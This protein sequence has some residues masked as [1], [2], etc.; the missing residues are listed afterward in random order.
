MKERKKK[1]LVFIF[2]LI[3]T[4][5]LF[6]LTYQSSQRKALKQLTE[7]HRIW[8]ERDV[9]YIITPNEKSVFLQLTSERE[10]D[11]FIEAFW[12]HR[13]PEPTT[14]ENEFKEEHYKRLEHANSY[15]GKESPGPGW[16]SDMGKIYII[17]GEP[18][19]IE[20]YES[21]A[22]MYP[23]H[24]WYYQGMSRFGLP[25]TFNIVYFKDKGIGE[26]RLYSPIR[27][28]PQELL[29]H[30]MGNR[31]DYVSAFREL[32]KVEPAVAEIS[33]TLIPGEN[34]YGA[35]RP[36]IASD[37]LI[38]EQIPSMP[39]RAVEDAYAEK[40]LKY[41]DIIEVD[42][43][44]N[45]IGNEASLFISRDETGISYVHYAIEPR[46]LSFELYQNSYHT[47]LDANVI[48]TDP[49]GKMVFQYERRIP[50]RLDRDEFENI[51]QK[52]FSFQDVFPL[53]EG[54]FKL[55]VLLKN[56]VTKEFTSIEAD[57][58]IPSAEA[59]VMTPPILANRMDSDS[60]Y[61]EKN[62][63]FLFGNRQLV[64]SPRN[65]FGRNDNLYVFFQVH[66]MQNEMKESGKIAYALL[67][68]DELVISRERSIA[69]YPDAQNFLEK[70]PLADFPP[71]HYKL[72]VSLLDASD[73][74]LL[75]ESEMFYV[76]YSPEL[77]RPWLLSVPLPPSSDP[78]Y[79]NI[80]GN[81]WLKTGNAQKAYQLLEEAYRR[82]PQ[83]AVFAMDY[84]RILFSRKKYSEV[85]QIAASFAD[86]SENAGFLG[87]MGDSSQALGE[88]AQA[89][90]YYKNHLERFG[91]NL[92]ILNSIGLCYL[93][94][95]NV[96]E[97]LVAWEKSL[98]I[99]PDQEALEKQVIKLRDQQIEND[100]ETA[101]VASG[102]CDLQ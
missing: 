72:Q 36:S 17:L 58:T 74:T 78:S 55:S 34:S 43:T 83:S 32:L 89:V 92:R 39:H 87:L 93:K 68:D 49:A 25:D 94:L 6:G 97:A 69:D 40:L 41:K 59:L 37:I 102:F 22:E 73:K 66:G 65:D 45:Y 62:K 38:E 91:T 52:L 60:Q 23:L 54:N 82:D 19:T 76:S 4:L 46:R 67:K 64:L 86:D 15:F 44:A 18:K 31:D 81:Q 33:L 96:T 70:F 61:G 50:I 90:Q 85:R 48:V 42:Y 26:Y 63:P 56:F 14:P 47:R 30:F 1:I 98:E 57:L 84:C 8:L 29:I 75:S 51:K 88:Y 11:I 99:N 10:R 71:A 24:I 77:P 27:F 2:I 35:I 13:D 101:A 20:R 21:Y 28:G 53:I 16:R 5:S 95:G 7:R 9:I 80:I 79:A 12:K 3:P 100:H